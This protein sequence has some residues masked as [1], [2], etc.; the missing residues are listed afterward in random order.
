MDEFGYKP[1]KSG[2]I[3]CMLVGRVVY[4]KFDAGNT[5]NSFSDNQ[6]GKRI[7]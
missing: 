4:W 3:N 5:Y 7:S 2:I 1:Q 6:H